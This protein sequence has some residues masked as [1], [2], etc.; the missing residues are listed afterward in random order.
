MALSEKFL[1]KYSAVKVHTDRSRAWVSYFQ[2]LAIVFILL[3]QY[4]TGEL[5]RLVFTYPLISF[6]LI[7]VV[8][9]GLLVVIGYVDKVLGLREAESKRVNQFNPDLQKIIKSV[10]EIKSCVSKTKG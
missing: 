5:G 2:F 4:G 9:F 1:E 7:V 8:F 10:E 6:P 3:K